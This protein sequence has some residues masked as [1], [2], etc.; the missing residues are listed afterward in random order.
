MAKRN[1]RL[2]RDSQLLLLRHVDLVRSLADPLGCPQR[3]MSTTLP[4]TLT[5]AR[6]LACY[7]KRRWGIWR[8]SS[9]SELSDQCSNNKL[10]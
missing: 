3:T 8:R 5:L 9:C 10:S 6:D 2:I 1:E 4:L 7:C